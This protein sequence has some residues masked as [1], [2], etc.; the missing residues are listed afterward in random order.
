MAIEFVIDPAGCIEVMNNPEMIT[1]LE[2]IGSVAVSAAQV[3]A[4]VATGHYRAGI[5]LTMS[6]EGGLPMA[7]VNADDFKSNW[8]E[9]G[10]AQGF[11]AYAC[12]RR[13]CEAAGVV[14]SRV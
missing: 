6:N 2:N 3:L 13:G 8:I 9:Y 7:T 10:T 5:N 4:P 1:F 14:V 11:P 12:V